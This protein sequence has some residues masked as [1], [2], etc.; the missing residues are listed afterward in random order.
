MISI[1]EINT[2]GLCAGVTVVARDASASGLL[3]R[4]FSPSFA[5]VPQ[6]SGGFSGI[7][8]GAVSERPIWAPVAKAARTFGYASAAD[9]AGSSYQPGNGDTTV[10]QQHRTMRAF[11]GL[12]P[13]RDPA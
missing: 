5:A 12:E 8:A 1:T 7:G 13:W 10:T 6:V 3:G 11:R 2:V 9:G 4:G